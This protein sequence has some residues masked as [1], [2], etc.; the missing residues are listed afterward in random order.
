MA[1]N[2][3]RLQPR[4][5]ITLN[6]F[7]RISC[8]HYDKPQTQNKNFVNL[9]R[10]RGSHSNVLLC[11]TYQEITELLDTIPSSRYPSS[12]SSFLCSVPFVCLVPSFVSSDF[13]R[14]SLMTP[15][16]VCT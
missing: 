16:A 4:H 2:S 11:R 14:T 6:E 10:K 15:S 12:L 13:P 3:S 9:R 5:P 7:S 8:V 1:V